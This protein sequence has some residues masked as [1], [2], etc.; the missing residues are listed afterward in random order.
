[1]ADSQLMSIIGRIN[2]AGPGP[3]APLFTAA[4]MAKLAAIP[5]SEQGLLQVV[6]D[7]SSDENARFIA[8]G[9]LVEGNWMGW[10]N[11]ASN[12]RAVAHVLVN[13]MA[14]DPTH[15]R[16]GLPGSFVGPFGKRL[17]SLG[18]EAEGELIALLSDS[19]PLNIEG[20]QAATLNSQFKFRLSALAAW[21]VADARHIPWQPSSSP[22][23]RDAEI[24]KLRAGLG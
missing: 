7:V 6:G 22:S 8:A 11:D 4:D 10:R 14:Q 19:R 17:L 23:E 24:A 12:R 20:S 16:W 13:A 3:D 5:S 1:M 18:V 21:L 2:P 9:A 15:N